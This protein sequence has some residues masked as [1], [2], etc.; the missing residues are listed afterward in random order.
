M[1]NSFGPS[2][3]SGCLPSAAAS[4]NRKGRHLSRVR[5]DCPN[6]GGL[7]IPNAAEKE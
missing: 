6:T 2:E 4:D 3:D 7:E 5:I 1:E